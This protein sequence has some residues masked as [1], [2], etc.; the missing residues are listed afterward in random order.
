[1]AEWA[2]AAVDPATAAANR[3]LVRERIAASGLPSELPEDADLTSDGP[4]ALTGYALSQV[5]VA[6]VVDRA[7]RERGLEFVNS[8]LHDPGGTWPIE[9]TEVTRWYREALAGVE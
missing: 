5:A 3:T 1:M 8:V 6:A 4:D 2:T 9:R 7:G